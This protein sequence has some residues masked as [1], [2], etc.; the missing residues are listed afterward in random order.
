MKITKSHTAQYTA[1]SN[2]AL[3]KYWGKQAHQIPENASISFTLKKCL[4]NTRIVVTP[5]LNEK[6]FIQVFFEGKMNEKFVPKIQK[7]FH[8]IHSILPWILSIDV[9]IHTENTFPHSSG[10]ASSASSMCALAAC[11]VD[12]HGQVYGIEQE[13]LN[14]ILISEIARLGSGSAARSVYP[15]IA[16]WGHVNSIKH[17]SN[18][19]AIDINEILHE[20]FAD[21]C[22]AILIV[23]NKE[24]SVSSTAGHSLMKNNSYATARYAQANKNCEKLIS[25]LQSGDEQAFVTLVEREALTL[26]ALMMASEPS[27]MLFESETIQIIKSIQAFRRE[28]NLSLCFTLD[29]GPNVHILYSKRIKKE[30]EYFIETQLKPFC[31]E[32]RVLYDELGLGIEKIKI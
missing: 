6:Q 24:K 15:R 30:V 7:M 31:Y 17:S 18:K 22:D 32:G 5:K 29:A 13:Q 10:I 3:V 8:E 23:S 19:Y 12:I 2:I 9:E 20:H 26:H 11:L 1:P 16:L 14:H 4:T 21:Y 25:I 27:F 28:T